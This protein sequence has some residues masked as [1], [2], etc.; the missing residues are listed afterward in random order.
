MHELFERKPSGDGD[1]VQSRRT[2]V[3]KGPYEKSY[4]LL[5]NGRRKFREPW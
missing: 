1:L 2:D 5:S 4:F 3:S